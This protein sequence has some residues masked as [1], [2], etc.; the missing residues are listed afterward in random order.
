METYYHIQYYIFLFL[1]LLLIIF[2]V[3]LLNFFQHILL[4]QF[5]QMVYLIF[6]DELL[7]LTLDFSFFWYFLFRDIHNYQWFVFL[8]QFFLFLVVV[9]FVQ[10]LEFAFFHVPFQ[11][12]IK[13]NF[14]SLLIFLQI[15]IYHPVQF[16]SKFYPLLNLLMNVLIQLVHLEK[17][18]E[19]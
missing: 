9:V 18:H 3:V 10:F 15:Q 14:F 11:K 17:L 19:W 2:L 5:F 4:L 8:Q 7:M 6:H 13:Y 1:L 12:Y 16:F